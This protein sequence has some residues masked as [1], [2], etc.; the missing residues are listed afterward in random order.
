MAIYKIAEYTHL[1]NQTKIEYYSETVNTCDGD[2]RKLYKLVNKLTLTIRIC[3]ILII[4]LLILATIL[5]IILLKN[6]EEGF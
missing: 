2:Q 1:C 6:N 5:V 4:I 3:Y